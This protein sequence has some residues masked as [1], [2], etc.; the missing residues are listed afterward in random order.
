MC[1][2]WPLLVSTSIIFYL[3]FVLSRAIPT[4][5]HGNPAGILSLL[6]SS[7]ILCHLGCGSHGGKETK[8]EPIG[9]EEKEKLCWICKK[10]S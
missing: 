6:V 3:F 8:R 10:M 4:L 2:C 9:I 1:E 7:K 5:C